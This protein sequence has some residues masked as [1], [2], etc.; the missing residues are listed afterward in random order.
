M[1]MGN[2]MNLLSAKSLLVQILHVNF[3]STIWLFAFISVLKTNW[4]NYMSTIKASIKE[5][6][7]TAIRTKQLTDKLKLLT[8][9]F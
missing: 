4:Q 6:N 1:Q 8:Y 9:I 2:T 3:L 7:A 5:K